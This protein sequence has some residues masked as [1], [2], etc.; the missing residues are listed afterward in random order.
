VVVEEQA[1]VVRRIFRDYLRGRVL[2]S[3]AHALNAEAVPPPRPRSQAGRP[4][5]WSF[6]AIHAILRNP[7]YRGERIWNR[8]EWIK[9]HNTGKRRKVPRD[10]SEW[11]RQND[12]AWRIVHEDTWEAVQTKIARQRNAMRSTPN[13]ASGRVPKP[14]HNPRARHLLAG[15]L[16]CGVC[17]GGFGSYS[18]S[19]R[20]R[21]SWRRDRGTTECNDAVV[22]A[23]AELEERL[24]A[25]IENQ[26][27]APNLDYIV[28]TAIATYERKQRE[29]G[30][31]A[32]R[33]ELAQVESEIRNLMCLAAKGLGD[34]DLLSDQIRDLERR[35]DALRGALDRAAV[36]LRPEALR[37]AIE[38]QIV[39]LRAT[40]AASVDDARRALRA[41]FDGER[42]RV[43]PKPQAPGGYGLEGAA[44]LRWSVMPDEARPGLQDEAGPLTTL[45]AGA[46]YA[47]VCRLP[48][49]LRLPVAGR[50]RPAA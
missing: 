10:E 24:L 35:R 14:E 30:V 18:S 46:C 20:F 50:I 44:V 19:G 42:L 2:R 34:L 28:E 47:R 43:L 12:E 22:V 27:L 11:V 45:V 16:E 23:S 39:D 21:C 6:N 37:P 1:A 41:L 3:I 26:V 38:A 7:L 31:E 40:L 9:D 48:R 13:S 8:T 49:P 15:L 29:A 17:G 25:A 32:K 5:S 4:P 36:A 33:M